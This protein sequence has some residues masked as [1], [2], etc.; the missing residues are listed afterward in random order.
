MRIEA[1]VNRLFVLLAGFVVLL[2]T[3]TA[4]AAAIR[5]MTFTG[6][7]YE[8]EDYPDPPVEFFRC[9]ALWYEE[10]GMRFEAPHFILWA[11]PAGDFVVAWEADLH[12]WPGTVAGPGE[13]HFGLKSGAAFDLISISLD[14]FGDPLRVSAGSPL[15]RFIHESEDT[16]IV[17]GWENIHGITMEWLTDDQDPSAAISSFT[18]RTAP[19][20]SVMILSLVGV[21]VA[22][23]RMRSSRQ[24]RT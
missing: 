3:S 15:I 23:L 2:F 11:P 6:G 7:S 5:T 17:F 14:V 21:G 18:I 16:P 13:M 19:E 9:N 4:E 1:N 20:P 22:A 8:C 10:A 24:K 12:G